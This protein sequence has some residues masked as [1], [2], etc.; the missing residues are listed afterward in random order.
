MNYTREFPAGTYNLY[1][2]LAGG[3][4]AATVTLGK[5]TAGWGTTEQTLTNLGTFSFVGTGW[6]TFQYVPLKDANGNLVPLTLS[7]TTTLRV[8]TGGGGDLNFLML[9]AADTNRPVISAVYPDGLMLLQSTNKFTFSAA[10]A[11]AA[12]N[13]TSIG[14]LLNGVDV[15]SDLV[16]SGTPNNKTVTYSGLLPNVASYTAVISVTNNNGLAANTTVVFDTFNPA[17]YSW[18]AEDYDYGGAQFIDNPQTNAYYGLSGVS[19]VDF[20]ESFVN[21]PQV[22]YRTSDPMGT[23]ETGDVPRLR[24][25]GT[26]DFNIGW[27]TAGEWVNYT[28][29]YP[30]GK[31]HVYGRFARGTGTNA[32][33][34]LSRVT[35]GVGTMTQTTV[36]L[37]SFSVDSHGWGTYNW[38]LLRDGS[39]EPVTLVLNGSV[40]TFRLTS[41]GPE[42]NTEANANFLM[43]LPIANPVTLNATLTGG[44]MVLSFDT[45]TGFSYQVQYKQQLENGSWSNLGSSISGNGTVQTVSDPATAGKRF[46]RLQVQ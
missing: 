11:G 34:V 12:I 6:S 41:A 44:N 13:D 43:L 36:D 31:Y 30:A 16:I 23:D 8:T 28:R 40:A 24:Y 9:V 17:L 10:S 29:T 45:E 33:P 20:H 42:D 26:N 46:Y 15:S 4:G 37:G 39:G 5:V 32:A 21:V 27:F 3:A 22:A 18:E 25:A 14:L 2:R 35:D 38:I 7:G 19:D 1:A